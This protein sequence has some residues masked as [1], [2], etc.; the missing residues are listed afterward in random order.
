MEPNESFAYV[1]FQEIQDAINA[2]ES[3]ELSNSL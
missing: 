2:K 1:S 3:K